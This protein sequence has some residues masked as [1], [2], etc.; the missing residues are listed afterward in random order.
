MLE[1]QSEKRGQLPALGSVI[2]PGGGRNHA[3]T[4][5]AGWVLLM[6]GQ[7]YWKERMASGYAAL[8]VGWQKLGPSGTSEGLWSGRSFGVKTAQMMISRGMDKIHII[9]REAF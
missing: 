8:A 7:L 9:G 2:L 1:P 3:A 6:F 5:W 4:S